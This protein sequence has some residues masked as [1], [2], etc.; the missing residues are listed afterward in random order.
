MTIEVAESRALVQ[1][2]YVHLQASIDGLLVDQE[3]N[4]C[5]TDCKRAQT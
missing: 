2:F 1:Q 3:L 5:M 4:K